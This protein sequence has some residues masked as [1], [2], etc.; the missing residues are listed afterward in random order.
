VLQPDSNIAVRI[1]NPR[2][3]LAEVNLHTDIRKST[4]CKERLI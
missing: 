3:N 4:P 1:S 2:V